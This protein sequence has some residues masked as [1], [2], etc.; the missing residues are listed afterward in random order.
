MARGRGS[1]EVPC[2]RRNLAM[3]ESHGVESHGVESDSCP[4]CRGIWLDR[5]EL[6][7]SSNLPVRHGGRRPGSTTM[8]TPTAAITTT[9]GIAETTVV[10]RR[11]MMAHRDDS[12]RAER[13]GSPRSVACWQ[14]GRTELRM[15]DGTRE[16]G[17]GA[18]LERPR[19]PSSGRPCECGRDSLRF[20]VTTGC[21]QLTSALDRGRAG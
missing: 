15:A 13:D 3:S 1:D 17:P 2:G 9:S 5:G 6:D 11:T 18:S 4:E 14:A 10:A 7:G 16:L 21:L 12:V 20:L 19:E 8:T